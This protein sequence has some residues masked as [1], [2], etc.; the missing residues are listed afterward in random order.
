MLLFG[1]IRLCVYECLGIAVKQSDLAA[2][3]VLIAQVSDIIPAKPNADPRALF[4]L[5]SPSCA[6]ISP[7]RLRA[8]GTSLSLR[9]GGETSVSDIVRPI[10]SILR[11]PNRNRR[12]LV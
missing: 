12:L 2:Q 9:S 6:K 10:W 5:T 7:S 1:S 4:A 11:L 8:E 3:R